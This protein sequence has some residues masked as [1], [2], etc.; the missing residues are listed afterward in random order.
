MS[1]FLSTAAA[2]LVL[3]AI[4]VVVFLVLLSRRKNA[5][6]QHQ[7]PAESGD[8]HHA[9]VEPAGSDQG[10]GARPEVA[11]ELEAAKE[12]QPSTAAP[13]GVFISYRRHDTG[14]YATM[15][16]KEFSSR[17]GKEQVFMDIDS[18]AI[19]VDFVEAIE[20]AV[21][22]CAVLLALIGP[23]WAT[24]TDEDGRRRLDDPDDKVRQEI[25]AGLARNILVIPVLTDGTS[26]P[27]RQH[28]PDSLALF[29]R[30]N[31]LQL[32]FDRYD[33]DLGRLLRVVDTAL[34]RR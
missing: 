6:P 21:D 1:D 12:A 4:A 25:E 5:P 19:G 34:G 30:R 18:I 23:Q 13:A 9:G 10:E 26:M 14:P 17:L 11:V 3:P 16:Q 33:Y 7:A 29:A 24:V 8:G 20:R 32:S 27:G 28:L 22:S 15:L 2:A 31:G